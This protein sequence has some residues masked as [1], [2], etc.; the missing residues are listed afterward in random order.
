[1]SALTLNSAMTS[2]DQPVAMDGELTYGRQ[3]VKFEGRV[4]VPRAVITGQQTGIDVRVT[5]DLLNAH[6]AGQVAAGTGAFTGNV[7]ASGPSLRRLLAWLVAPIAAGY[8]LETFTV[9]GVLTTAP[10]QIAFENAS[11]SIDAIRGRGD[12]IL[13]QLRGKPYVSG[14]LEL[15][16]VDV[17]PYLVAATRPAAESAEIA[18]AAA[19][20]ARTIDVDTAPSDAPFD[21]S[22]LQ[23]INADLEL[24]TGP[25]K[26]QQMHAT[27]TQLALVINDGFLAATIH[28]LEMYGGSGRGRLEFDARTPDVRLVQELTA[29]GVDARAFMTDAFGFSNLSG[30][31]ELN[32]N[33]RTQGRNQSGLIRALDGRVSFELVS[34]ALQGVDLGGVATT[35]RRALNNDLI[36][37]DARTPLTGMSATF[38]ISDGVMASDSISFNTPD[39]RLRGLG[40]IDLSARSMDLRLV[41]QNAV[42]AIPFRVHGPWD[43]LGYAGDLNGEARRALEPRVRAVRAASVAP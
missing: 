24:T 4:D 18:A 14:R 30:R 43:L 19:A 33:V 32:L 35:I 13:Q 42:L 16:D 25:F 34:G 40:I 31:T 22:G 11:M 37:P 17:N 23:A 9:Q 21:F 10:N 26:I 1:M 6:L 36:Q 29:D 27:R 7:D 38:A 15:F 12:F 28:R 8:G 41:P 39:L 2:L 3:A 20:P 5:S